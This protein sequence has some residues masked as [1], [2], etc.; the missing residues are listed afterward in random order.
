MLFEEE[1]LIPTETERK[2]QIYIEQLINDLYR[3]KK[4]EVNSKN[5]L[6]LLSYLTSNENISTQMKTVTEYQNRKIVDILHEGEIEKYKELY[7][8]VLA[9]LVKADRKNIENE[10]VI[11]LMAETIRKLAISLA[12]YKGSYNKE[13]INFTGNIKGIKQYFERKVENGN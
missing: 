5:L 11:N 6:E 10:M 8:K 4:I 3:N 2:L 1:N 9:D 13:T 7:N 12:S